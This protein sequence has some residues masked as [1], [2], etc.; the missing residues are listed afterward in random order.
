MAKTAVFF[1][2][3]SLWLGAFQAAG[4]S[5]Q[6]QGKKT[7]P[8]HSPLSWTAASE[9][10]RLTEKEAA[11]NA[12]KLLGVAP[13]AIP[14]AHLVYFRDSENPALKSEKQLAWLAEAPAVE[15][16]RPEYLGGGSVRSLLVVCLDAQDG[17]LVCV[18][19]PAKE[20]W[21]MPAT[22]APKESEAILESMRRERWTIDRLNGAPES[23]GKAVLERLWQSFAIGPGDAGQIIAR[24]VQVQTQYPE[25]PIHRVDVRGDGV[26][27]HPVRRAWIMATMGGPR[28]ELGHTYITGQRWLLMDGTGKWGAGLYT[29]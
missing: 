5:D 15:I 14:R 20:R 12:A 22:G 2:A 11:A 13:E 17:T 18:F 16:K 27:V 10:T 23:T 24:P 9:R 3:L 19:T 29:P 21:L 28:E 6:E 4:A 25:I 7:I 26:S 1:C 8:A